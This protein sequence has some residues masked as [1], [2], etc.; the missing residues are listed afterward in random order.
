MDYKLRI[1][2]STFQVQFSILLFFLHLPVSSNAQET[3]L[4]FVLGLNYTIN[5]MKG[6]KEEDL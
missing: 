4:G 2:F 6:L 1:D 3:N 5:R